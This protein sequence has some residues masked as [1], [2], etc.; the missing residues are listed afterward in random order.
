VATGV[1]PV[2][3]SWSC[4]NPSVGRGA[5]IALLHVTALRDLLRTHSLDDPIG[6]VLAWDEATA[7]T[8]TPWYRETLWGDRHRLAELDAAIEGRPYSP[9]DPQYE[10]VRALGAMGMMSPDHLRAGIRNGM[11]IKTLDETF[12]DIGRDTILEKGGAWRD[13]P[14][15]GPSR[16]DLLKLLS[17]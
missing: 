6:F 15:M 14:V 9:E 2:G 3:D 11:L 1:A 4:S 10:L 12:D 7:A 16:Q 13:F 17:S 8:V 5:S